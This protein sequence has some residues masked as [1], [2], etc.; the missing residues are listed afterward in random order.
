MPM[1]FIIHK[2]LLNHPHLELGMQDPSIYL[3]KKNE[4]RDTETRDKLALS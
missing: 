3:I 2:H 4:S 1:F